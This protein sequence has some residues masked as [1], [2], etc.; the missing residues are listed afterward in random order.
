VAGENR[1]VTTRQIKTVA[2][3]IKKF[4][5]KIFRYDPK[6]NSLPFHIRLQQGG[7]RN[8]KTFS[9]KLVL[10]A[11]A[12]RKAK[13][14][15]DF[16]TTNGMAATWAKYGDGI[17]E[18]PTETIGQLLA[19]VEKLWLGRTKTFFEYA[20]EVRRVFSDIKGL[21]RTGIGGQGKNR[22]K[23]LAKVNAIKIADITRAAV[24]QWRADYIKQR[25]LGDEGKRQAAETT[26][27][28]ILRQCKALFSAERLEQLE[29]AGLPDPFAKVKFLTSHNHRFVKSVKATDLLAKA[30]AELANKEN[31]EL[32]KALLLCLTAGLRRGEADAIE[33]SA[34]DFDGGT[35]HVGVTEFIHPKSAKSVGTIALEREVIGL[36][37]GWHAKSSSTFVLESQ[38]A[39]KKNARFEH[40]RAQKTFEKLAVWLRKAGVK[41]RSPVHG[42]RKL[43]GSLICDNDGIYAASRALRHA[44]IQTTERHYT[45]TREGVVTGLGSI[46]AASSKVVPI[47]QPPN[48]VSN[49]TNIVRDRA[50][51]VG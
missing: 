2:T 21:D 19:K 27:N 34:F 29:L 4:K 1:A 22:E 13:E 46:L 18:I 31:E 48:N 38:V 26:S 42:L 20:A 43:Y 17:E 49:K 40:Y 37:R 45:D 30:N 7:T 35:L 12:A 16:L 11:D 24:E 5:Q 47:N 3:S 8:R 9:T 10:E 23:W 39:P 50:D 41:D 33:W 28:T 32:F 51:A 25:G 36:F 44:D 14:I 6:N 15:S